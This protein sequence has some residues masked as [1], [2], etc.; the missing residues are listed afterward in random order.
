[1]IK[2]RLTESAVKEA[3]AQGQR[4]LLLPK[5]I[6]ATKSED[7]KSRPPI[8]YKRPT[9]T[10]DAAATSSGRAV[11]PPIR[12]FRSSESRKSVV[13]DV[14]DMPGRHTSADSY[15]DDALDPN[16]RDRALRTLE[17]RHNEDFS[18]PPPSDSGEMTTTTDNDNTADIFMKIAREDPAPRASEKQ[19][20]PAEPSV[21]VSFFV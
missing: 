9:T 7:K 11:I 1:V 16:Q 3:A 10:A 19:G 4:I 20:A 2:R 15:N 12:A 21:V 14:L 17:G 13:L 5:I 18:P 6:G 8:S